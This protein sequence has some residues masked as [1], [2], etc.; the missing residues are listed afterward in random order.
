MV[1]SYGLAPPYFQTKLRPEKF[2]GDRP[3]LRVWMTLPPPPPYLKVWIR[4]WISRAIF[5]KTSTEIYG[6]KKVQEQ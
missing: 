4:H 2:F 3:Y 1:K 6:L 5:R